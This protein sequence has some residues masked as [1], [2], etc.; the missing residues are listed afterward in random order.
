MVLVCDQDLFTLFVLYLQ[1]I[2]VVLI[3]LYFVLQVVAISEDEKSERIDQERNF[4]R[5]R[6]Y[7]AV[8]N[9][10]VFENEVRAVKPYRRTVGLS[11][12]DCEVHF[13]QHSLAN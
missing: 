1:E 11:D 9:G 7:A 13:Q 5:F 6:E 8:V 4:L 10:H 12:R 2:E 3:E